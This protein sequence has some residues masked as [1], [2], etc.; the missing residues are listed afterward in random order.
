MAQI[1]G[2]VQA[3]VSPLPSNGDTAVLHKAIDLTVEILPTFLYHG[4][5]LILAWISNYTPL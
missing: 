4:L 5:A 3:A 2:L 1:D